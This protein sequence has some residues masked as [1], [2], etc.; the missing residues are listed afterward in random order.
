MTSLWGDFL[1]H[2]D[3]GMFKWT[4]YF[5][6][7][8][9]HFARFVNRP[10]VFW[11]IGVG[12]GGSLQMWKRYLGPQAQIVG[13]DISKRRAFEEEQVAVRIGDQSDPAFLQSVLDEFGTP[14]AVLDDG[15]HIMKHVKGTFAYLYP[16]ISPVGVYMVEDMQT[17]YWPEFGGGLREPESFVEI[18]KG[19]IDELNAEHSLG[20]LEP[21]SFTLTTLSMHFYDGMVV[22]ERGR[23]L[24]KHPLGVGGS[25]SA[26]NRVSSRARQWAGE[27]KTR[28]W[29]DTKE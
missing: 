12:D 20:A 6:A 3:R 10:I 7:Y 22:F 18:A 11:E 5:P 25:R 29:G 13:L 23:H 4:H 19:L 14:D 24:P 15:S 1:T 16:R 9:Q 17:A 28:H 26:T 2:R 27:I 21:T 8:E